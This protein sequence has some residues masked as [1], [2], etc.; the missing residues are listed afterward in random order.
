MVLEELGRA[1]APVAFLTSSVIA[2]TAL[3]QTPAGGPASDLLAAL[4]SGEAVAALA[5]SLAAAGG[6]VPALRLDAAGRVS[7]QVRS[8]AGALD[9][10]VFLVPVGAADGMAI[11]CVASG[12]AA[13]APVTSLDM[14]R[15]LADLT[16]ADASSTIVVPGDSGHPAVARALRAGAALLASERL[17]IA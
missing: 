1:V 16:F 7:G 13:V 9:A 2:T 6:D 14:T 10:D 4:A 11:A 17:G 5:V 8:V 15:Q 3:L 12:D